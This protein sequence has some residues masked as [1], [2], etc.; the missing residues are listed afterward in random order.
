MYRIE[1][2][3]LFH[4][5][6]A[7]FLALT[8]TALT[9]AVAQT[10]P[11]TAPPRPAPAARPPLPRPGPGDVII[12]CLQQMHGTLTAVP[13]HVVSGSPVTLTWSAPIPR[14][15]TDVRLMLHN[16]RLHQNQ[17]VGESGSIVV[18]PVIATQYTLA[19][20]R[21]PDP[22]VTF[23]PADIVVT[24]PHVVHI[25]GNDQEWKLLLREAVSPENPNANQIVRLAPDV[26]M[27]LTGFGQIVMKSGVT[28][29]GDQDP[30]G[31]IANPGVAVIARPAPTAPRIDLAGD[32]PSRAGLMLG[33]RLY[34]RDHL[35]Y[36]Q[37]HL[38]C[39]ANGANG[40]NV[41]ITGFRLIGPDYGVVGSDVQ[42]TGI[43]VEA[44]RSVEIARME[45][46]GWADQGIFIGAH[47]D[48]AH[49]GMPDPMNQSRLEDPTPANG[50]D[51]H[52]PWIHDNYIHNNQNDELGYGVNVG[53]TYA[54]I[55]HNVFDF[56]R[57]GITSGSSD[58]TGYVAIENLILRGG[59]VEAI[60]LTPLTKHAQQIDVHGSEWHLGAHNTGQAGR[61]FEIGRN[62]VQYHAT[63]AVKI[64]GTPIAP[65]RIIGNVFPH[66]E[67]EG[68]HSPTADDAINL[69]SRD[70]IELRGNQT[71]FDSFGQYGV[72]DF[73]GDGRDDLFLP[74]R[75]GWWY[76]SGAR[77]HWVFLRAASEDMDH[78]GLGYFD[79]DRRC[80][81]VAQNGQHLMI[82]SGGR[83]PW[84]TLPGAYPMPF[85]QL[86][87]IDFDR[88]GTTDIFWRMPNGRWQ[89]TA[90]LQQAWRPLQSSSYGISQLRFAN[91]APDPDN[92]RDHR[93]DRTLDVLGLSNGRIYYSRDAVDHWQPLHGLEYGPCDRILVGDVDGNGQDDIIRF[94]PDP[95]ASKC[96]YAYGSWQI[97]WSGTTD[98]ATVAT[99]AAPPPGPNPQHGAPL[100]PPPFAPLFVG[101]FDSHA[102]ADLLY[103]DQGRMGQLYS[104]ATNHVV[105]QNL[106]AY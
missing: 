37:I 1:I 55:E 41:L 62:A 103:I 20:T 100:R 64:R 101:R 4:G 48:P 60:T 13:D 59:G 98:W 11:A 49:N 36:G 19:A 81:V 92:P 102:G 71:G 83:G 22:P 94:T 70:N 28:L 14:D 44:C 85:D 25:R 16:T 8:V 63:Y 88:D 87:F 39:D 57:H 66:S 72:C 43:Y 53:G 12:A 61:E 5:L 104:H 31:P 17:P 30:Q 42:S 54:R 82:S 76:A 89:V 52:A 77:M 38:E 7:V 33:P 96:Q 23:A 95:P 90:P 6:V 21:P 9:S 106:Y 34:T 45:V 105:P 2:Q 26:D 50:F 67:E 58:H 18:N 27:D 68:H 65:S 10:P 91:L 80:D 84:E 78:L 3:P 24:F 32:V 86:R 56:N 46:A 79:G 75:T 15:C 93:T 74:T 99:M 40:D 35:Q 97:S 47:T 51:S 69:V 73:D 29:T